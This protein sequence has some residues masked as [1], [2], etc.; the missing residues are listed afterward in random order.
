METNERPKKKL[1]KQQIIA[2]IITVIVLAAAITTALCFF[3]LSIVGV[4]KD[5]IRYCMMPADNGKWEYYVAEIDTSKTSEIRIAE[6]INGL[7]VT[8]ISSS[9]FQKDG[10][11]HEGD[12]LPN[13]NITSIYLPKS[14]LTISGNFSDCANL[15]TLIVE[16]GNPV[17][18]SQDNCIIET[19]SK[20]LIVGCKTSVI[21]T[22]GS[23][24]NI[25]EGAFSNCSGLEKITIPAN[26][27]KIGAHAFYNC[28]KLQAVK[29]EA[30]ACTNAG[31]ASDPIFANC[32]KLTTVDIGKNVTMIPA[33]TFE[34]C[35][36]LNR[37]Y[38]T[39][40]SKWCEISFGNE[41]A[42]PLYYAHKIYLIE[43][44]RIVTDLQIPYNITR[45]NDYAFCGCSNNLTIPS[46]ITEIGISSFQSVTSL[47][48][49]GTRVQ[50]NSIK[51]NYSWGNA[52]VYC[53]D[54]EQ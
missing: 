35:N 33:C 54:D 18:H 41:T 37:I 43:N 31:S 12:H 7:P 36:N 6:K 26:I 13:G 17:Y 45:I 42:N 4:T 29:W 23:V 20:T 46:S 16:E 32:K 25:G 50:W 22:D 30:T 5:G 14:I 11:F 21:P 9:A 1:T 51:K 38:I 53:T 48:F 8:E 10:A 19:E 28:N 2:I 47:N 24:T 34:Q 44:N 15:T 49:N 3:L 27:S 52:T 39:D 40:L